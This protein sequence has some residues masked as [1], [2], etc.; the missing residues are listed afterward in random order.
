MQ[1][2]A[3]RLLNERKP[4]RKHRKTNSKT[5]R[6]HGNAKNTNVRWVLLKYVYELLGTTGT[7]WHSWTAE[8]RWRRRIPIGFIEKWIWMLGNHWQQLT[9]LKTAKEKLLKTIESAE[10]LLNADLLKM[11][12]ES[13]CIH[14][15]PMGFIEKA[16]WII[17]NC[18]KQAT[19]LKNLLKPAESAEFRWALMKKLYASLEITGNRWLRW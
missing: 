15:I 19:P 1:T 8:N 11:R 14:W 16:I 2:I 13:L 9:P 6:E 5:V 7:N 12:Y 18:S 4:L 10:V 17:G 3:K